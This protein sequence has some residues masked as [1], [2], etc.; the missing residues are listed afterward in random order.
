[1]NKNFD[2][3]ETLKKV[4]LEYD[5]INFE[6]IMM[7]KRHIALLNRLFENCDLS[8]LIAIENCLK[9]FFSATNIYL[10]IIRNP[11]NDEEK[12]INSSSL[13]KIK[14][15]AEDFYAQSNW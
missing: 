8:S 14:K 15:I 7:Q 4:S 1:M 12:N 5:S 9:E 2:P 6:G 11:I 13:K 3:Y 10:R